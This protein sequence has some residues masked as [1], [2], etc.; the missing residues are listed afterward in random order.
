VNTLKSMVQGNFGQVAANY[1]TSAVHVQGA[2][3]ARLVELA[4][5][6]G[7]EQVLDAGCGAGHTGLA[8]AAGASQ[9]VACDFTPAMLEQVN[10]LARERGLTNVLTQPGDVEDLPFDDACFDLVVTRYSAHHWPNPV[11]ALHE[12]RRVLNPGGRLL[13]SDIVAPESPALDTFLQTLELLRDLSH[14]RD[15]RVSEWID[16]LNQAGFRAKV[17]MT[18]RL[19]LNFDAWVTRIATPE[20]YVVALRLLLADAPSEA[21]SGFEIQADGSFTLDG[22]LFLGARD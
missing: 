10:R 16:M 22:A 8:L 19:P 14:V 7:R 20:A 17:D 9:V 4:A 21:R 2:D 1:A 18:W 3:L 15:H 12:F 5:L 11:R 6:T 13:V